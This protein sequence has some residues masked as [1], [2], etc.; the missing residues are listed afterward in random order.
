MLHVTLSTLFNIKDSSFVNFL[1][2]LTSLFLAP[3]SQ[4]SVTEGPT[5]NKLPLHLPSI[6]FTV[7]TQCFSFR[8][9][10]LMDPLLRP[11]FLLLLLE[12]GKRSLEDHT[13]LFLVLAHTTSYTDDVL[14]SFYDASL[15]TVSVVVWRWSLRGFCR[16]LWSG[17]GSPFTVC[18]EGDLTSAAPDPVPSACPQPTINAV[19]APLDC[20]LPV[21]PWWEFPSTPPPTSEDLTPP[22]LVDPPAPPWLLAPSSPP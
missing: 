12:Q 14:C 7:F 1:C 19:W 6:L 21:S 18:P 4:R 17:H 2:F 9:C 10:S 16:P 3:C 15:N 8:L 5:Y 11:E 22:R 13:R 20:H